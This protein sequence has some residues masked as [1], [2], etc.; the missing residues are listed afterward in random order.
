MLLA[1]RM[2]IKKTAA[3]ENGKG[4]LLAANPPGSSREYACQN[5]V[6]GTVPMTTV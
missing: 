6:K 2:G 1:E 5:Y 4:K 3:R